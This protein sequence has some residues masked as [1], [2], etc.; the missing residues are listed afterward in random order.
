MFTMRSS[1]VLSHAHMSSGNITQY[2]RA[3]KRDMANSAFPGVP[4]IIY[5]GSNLNNIQN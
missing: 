2:D 5:P 1:S 3:T 4:T